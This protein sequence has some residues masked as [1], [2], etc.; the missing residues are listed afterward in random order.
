M[1]FNFHDVYFPIQPIVRK[2]NAF[3]I[4]GRDR[5]ETNKCVLCSCS[6]KCDSYI[7]PWQGIQ[8]LVFTPVRL[9]PYK[10]SEEFVKCHRFSFNIISK[11]ES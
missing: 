8:A 6:D 1:R 3:C 9:I 10:F 5:P 4:Q 7:K 2:D 11:L